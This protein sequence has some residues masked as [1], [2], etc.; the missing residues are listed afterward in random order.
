MLVAGL[1]P[2]CGVADLGNRIPSLGFVLVALALLWSEF[3]A[4]L[5]TASNKG[6]VFCLLLL[7]AFVSPFSLS[8]R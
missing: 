8:G 3:G 6:V 2:G 4:A 1:V 5:A 7:V